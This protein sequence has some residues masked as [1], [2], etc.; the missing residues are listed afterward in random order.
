MRGGRRPARLLTGMGLTGGMPVLHKFVILS[1]VAASRSEAATQSKDPYELI[2]SRRGLRHHLREVTVK[3]IGV[4]RLQ[5]S[6]RK[7]PLFLRS[8]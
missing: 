2:G 1:G 3:G 6:G 7:R 5:K 4:L 8:A